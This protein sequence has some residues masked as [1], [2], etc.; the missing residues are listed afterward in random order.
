MCKCVVRMA[1]MDLS[2]MVLVHIGQRHTPTVKGNVPLSL[3]HTH[4]QSIRHI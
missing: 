4:T 2:E 3:S 1:I